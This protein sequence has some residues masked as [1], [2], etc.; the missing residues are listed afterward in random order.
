MTDEN[1][2]NDNVDFTDEALREYAKETVK[3]LFDSASTDEFDERGLASGNADSL[4]TSD[5]EHHILSNSI[6]MKPE[7]TPMLLASEE[8]ASGTLE[9]WE[10][11][12]VRYLYLQ[13]K[14]AVQSQ[15]DLQQKETLQLSY[16]RAMMSFLLFQAEPKSALLLGLGG[17][18]IAHFLSYWFPDLKITAVDNNE[19]IVSIGEKYF[20]LSTIPQLNID[21]TDASAYLR[22]PKQKNISVIFVDVHDGRCLPDFL[23]DA[24]FMAQCFQALSLD[25]V[26]VINLLINKEQ[27]FTDILTALRT[28]FKGVSFC[29][30][31]KDQKNILLFAFRSP[32][33]LD[34]DDLKAKASQCKKKYHIEFDVF[35]RGI[36]QV[37]E[38]C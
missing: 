19:S 18:G 22:K 13:D 32:S 29:M 10:A 25:G 31:F 11:D 37:D 2:E 3:G 7:N 12:S 27:E 4:G 15:L 9:V 5:A 24:E 8:T 6:I 21:I 17:G 28:S 1:C 38:K 26:L 34:I 36:I 33:L 30:T 23:Y 35:V 14:L 20:S 16:T